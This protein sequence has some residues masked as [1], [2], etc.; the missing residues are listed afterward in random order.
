MGRGRQPVQTRGGAMTADVYS[1]ISRR[2]WRDAKFLALSAPPPNARDLWIYLLTGPHNT[3]IPGLWTIGVLGLAEG[4]GWAPA[5]V[6]RCLSELEASGM[7]VADRTARLLWAPNAIRHHEPQN[8][9]HVLGWRD[10][11]KLVPECALRER[12]REALAAYLAE[13]DEARGSDAREAGK[14]APAHT[15]AA[16]LA[17]VTSPKPPRNHGGIHPPNHPP[18]H[19]GTIP[20][21][22]G[23]KGSGKGKGKGRGEEPAPAPPPDGG[24]NPTEQSIADTLARSERL[25]C[26]ATPDVVRRFAALTNGDGNA[27]PCRLADALHALRDADAREAV[28]VA[29]G[30]VP[31]SPGALANYALG[32]IKR[33]RRGE[34]DETGRAECGA[35]QTAPTSH[36]HP[37]VGETMSDAVPEPPPFIRD[38]EKRREWTERWIRSRDAERAARAA[39]AGG[40]ET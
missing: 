32:F 6:D 39:Q 13:R 28:G 15:F 16:A 18:K 14:P 17:A 26:L 29:A 36:E 25:R 21:T 24:L 11:W 22:I 38:P 34:A 1:P 3:A 27:G 12:A 31:R 9:N 10:A 37:H 35:A 30:E 40:T 8:P 23:D 33:V 20:P 2:M 7:V 19:D 4:I 5:D